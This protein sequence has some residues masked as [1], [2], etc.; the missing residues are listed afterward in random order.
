MTSRVTSASDLQKKVAISGATLWVSN[1]HNSPPE[2]AMRIKL[3]NCPKC[4]T[5]VTEEVALLAP[6]HFMRC[7][8]AGCDAFF[9]LEER[10]MAG[11]IELIERQTPPGNA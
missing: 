10:D 5:E 11:I 7:A 3:L 1:V 9:V 8:G 6:H 4:G 2:T